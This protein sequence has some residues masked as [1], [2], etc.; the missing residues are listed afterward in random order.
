[1]TSAQ[2][3]LCTTSVRK[4]RLLRA[5]ERIR[6]RNTSAQICVLHDGEVVLNHAFGCKEDALFWI[7]LASKPFMAMLIYLLAE[8]GHVRLDEPV[9]TYWPEFAQRGMFWSPEWEPMED[10]P[11]GL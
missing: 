9:A 8:R 3:D 4:P 1:M 7:F 10:L 2:G 11:H 6:D 5:L